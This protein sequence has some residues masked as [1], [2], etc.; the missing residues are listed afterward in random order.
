MENQ[1]KLQIAQLDRDTQMMKLAE[2][3]NMDLDKIKAQLQDHREE[4]EHK[5]RKMAAEIAVERNR[6]EGPVVA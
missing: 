2:T 6:P 1:T 4:R 5:E 3:M